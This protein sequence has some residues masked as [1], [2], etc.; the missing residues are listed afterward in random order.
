[1][2]S[3]KKQQKKPQLSLLVKNSKL[4]KLARLVLDALDEGFPPLVLGIMSPA[5]DIRL[6]YDLNV[7]LGW[8]L[9]RYKD[10]ICRHSKT[11]TR[12][13]IYRGNY[14]GS[15][16][17]LFWNSPESSEWVSKTD[18]TGAGLFSKEIE[19]PPMLRFLR[20]PK[21]I[22]ALLTID[23]ELSQNEMVILQNRLSM[24]PSLVNYEQI[25]WLSI[26]GRENLLF[27]P[28]K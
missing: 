8:A 22:S 12:H 2:V 15:S 9:T 14:Y 19:E 21:N 6:V 18:Q 1:M 27:E 23:P 26:R 17:S 11:L 10:V 24:S 28:I 3:R 4:I 16:I 25:P 13:A 5:Q 7:N 20:K